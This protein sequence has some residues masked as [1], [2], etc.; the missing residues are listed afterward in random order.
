MQLHSFSL[1]LLRAALAA[2]G[3]LPSS[4]L[5]RLSVRADLGLSLC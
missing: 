3:L 2:W 4:L 1:S 5:S